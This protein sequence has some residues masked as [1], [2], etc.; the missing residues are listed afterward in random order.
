MR[1]T[2]WMAQ[3]LGLAVLVLVTACGTQAPVEV[4][5][6]EP[7]LID[8]ELFFGNPEISGAQISP[9]GELVS[10]IQ[11]Y[12]NGVRNIWIKGR[13]EAF[14]DARPLTADDRPVPGYFWS[15]DGRYV[16]YVQDKGG[17]EDFHIYAVDPRAELAE[18]ADVPP[19]RNLTPLDGVR[20]T[21][22]SVPERTPNQILIGLNDRDPRF[23]DVYRL[24]LTTGD[25]ELLIQ[26]TAQVAF[27][28]SDLD[29]NVRLAYRQTADGGSEVLKVADGKLGEI[30]YSCNYR[31]TC[32]PL[33]FHKDGKRVYFQSN[34]GDDVDLIRLLLMDAETGKT[35]LVEADPE[36]EV[37]LGG[38]V[39]DEATEELMATVYVGDRQRVYP[40]TADAEAA[41]ATL[42]EKLPDGD[43]GL[44]SQTSDSEAWIVYVSRDVDPGSAYLFD[45][46][47]GTVEKLYS[48]RPELPTEHL[49]EMRP[50]RYAS[51]DGR[52]IPAYL[53]LPRGKGEKNLPVVIMPHGGP[54]AR[55]TWG[56]SSFAQF[57][58]N[59]GY[60]VLQPN[61]RGSAGFGK[62]FLN[63]GNNEWGT[64]YMQHDITDG[65]KYL[66]AEGIAD[67]EK[68]CIMGGSYGGYATLAGLAFTPDL[69]ACG[70]SIV[71]PSNLITLLNSI[72][73]YWESI[74][75]VFN[76]R[77]GDPEDP[78]DR[79]RLIAQ[80]PLHSAEKIKAP[81][82]VIQGAND[83][84]V[85]KAESDQIVEAMHRLG[86]EVEYMVAPDE[87]HG[88]RSEKNRLAMN[89]GF[90]KFLSEQ[91]G[92]RFQEEVN[93]ETAAHLE[94]L[95]VDP[96]SVEV[97]GQPEVAPRG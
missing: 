34:K 57:L 24:D 42:R 32:Q 13:D 19:A 70:V 55:D 49:A 27:W 80:S 53:T 25:R 22:Y 23:H 30:I 3:A 39:F 87:G 74:R 54:W 66:V 95:W 77:L 76:V 92:G 36:G 72:P 85:K 62:D 46:A 6:A 18:G 21:I 1:L 26:N 51:R 68:V 14:A 79:E 15:A 43:L 48:S 17:N 12:S 56:Y 82:L 69:Y 67:P 63:A 71:G 83:P 73:P 65:V 9:D 11:E 7:P 35:E 37:D 44:G 40:K 94:T 86:R 5:E 58:A 45:R 84:R 29:G 96:A 88:F 90:E 8:R 10:F 2:R 91:L 89:V 59:R 61:F 93:P 31:E 41:L 75:K 38:A 28:G 64:G 4:T 16:L 78:E 50:V 97:D 60:A 20:A 52:E 33:R 81:L 47:E